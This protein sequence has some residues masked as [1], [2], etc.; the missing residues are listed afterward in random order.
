MP[1]N[2]SGSTSIGFQVSGTGRVIS[3]FALTHFAA[4][5]EFAEKTAGIEEAHT[6]QAFGNFWQEISIYWSAA[7]M[8]SVAALESLINELYLQTNSPLQQVD[9]E[10]DE[11]F[12]GKKGLERNPILHK[13]QTAL[14]QLG[15][16]PFDQ[17]SDPY[18]AVETLIGL[19]NYIVHFKP[20]FDEERRNEDLE[21]KLVDRFE[22]SPFLDDGADF[23]TKKCVSGGCARWAV[24][25]SRSFICTFADLSGLDNKKLSAFS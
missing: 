17:D 5:S 11:F 20:L 13:Y 1:S 7:I 14:A 2:L 22:L 9:G 10:F 3:N 8:S 4:A 19:R 25:S 16:D 15:I 12:W 6:G 24:E 21:A 23:V 18:A